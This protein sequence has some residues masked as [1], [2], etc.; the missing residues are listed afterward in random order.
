VGDFDTDTAVRPGDDGALECEIGPDWWVAAGPN[1]GYLAAI[2][3]R[4][5]EAQAGADRRPLRSLTVH[6][7]RAPSAA[8]ARVE[9]E[10]EREGR[11][12]SFARAR[13]LQ[14]GRP[15]ALAGAVLADARAGLELEHAEFP[16]VE[17][18][19]A[20]APARHRAD[21]PPFARQFEFRQ[22]VGARV[23]GR[24]EEAVTGGWVRLRRER[25]LDAALLVALCDSWFPAV[26]ALV[27]EPRPVPT[28][29][30]T[31]HLR[32]DGGALPP[33]WVLGRF[34]TRTARD[35]FLEE[36]G[37]IY[38]RD[39]RLLAQSRQLALSS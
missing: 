23:F 34:T 13:L 37:E 7:L 35:G 14:D 18:P 2:L 32:T 6:Y 12:V 19:D 29:E 33:D 27:D 11:S 17:P 22:A 26:F 5:L 15:C 1:G 38:S 24:G 3:V 28:L 10:I 25:P 8:P 39:G 21:P 4:A 36:D 20:I 16:E 31:V 9:V 30:L